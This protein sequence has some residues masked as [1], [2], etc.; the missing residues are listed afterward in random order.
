MASLFVKIFFVFFLCGAF[1]E[2]A[3]VP[4][5]KR[6]FDSAA[7]RQKWIN[8]SCGCLGSRCEVKLYLQAIK[9]LPGMSYKEVI[10]KLGK[11]N[12]EYGD[13]DHAHWDCNYI[14]QSRCDSTGRKT[15]GLDLDL[16]FENDTVRDTGNMIYCG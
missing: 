14:I 6:D 15:K 10:E 3:N 2:D 7:E 16:Y 4:D 12:R 11:P 5:P 8:D 1:N 9:G 13:A